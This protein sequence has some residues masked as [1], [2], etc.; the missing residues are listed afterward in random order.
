LVPPDEDLPG[1]LQ[2]HDGLLNQRDVRILLLA[3]PAETQAI[4]QRI[5]PRD[6]RKLALLFGGTGGQGSSNP[7]DGPWLRKTHTT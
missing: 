6:V 7:K 3:P 2:R 1:I 4:L 5:R